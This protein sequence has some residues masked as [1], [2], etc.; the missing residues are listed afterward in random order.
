MTDETRCDSCQAASDWYCR[1]CWL[2][3]VEEGARNAAERDEAR[4]EAE[5]LRR[6]CGDLTQQL[7]VAQRH[8]DGLGRSL[9]AALELLERLRRRVTVDSEETP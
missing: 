9:Y 8:T 4:A 5:A 6:E 3:V 1:A 2:E 7:A